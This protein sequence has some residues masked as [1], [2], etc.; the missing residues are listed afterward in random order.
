MISKMLR[1]V[2]RETQREKRASSLSI[3]E[4]TEIFC[5]HCRPTRENLISFNS[6]FAT[7][8]R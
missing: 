2:S 4:S 1:N 3:D 7:S 5:G 8:R 6:H